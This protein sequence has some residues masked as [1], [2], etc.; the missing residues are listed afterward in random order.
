MAIVKSKMAALQNRHK[1]NPL[2]PQM[3]V[4]VFLDPTNVGI[5]TGI[6]VLSGLITEIMTILG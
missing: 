6:I 1:G 2:I 4:I 5:D 3:Y